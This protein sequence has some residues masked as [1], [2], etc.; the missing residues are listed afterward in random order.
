MNSKK[1]SSNSW[2]ARF[3]LVPST[4]LKVAFLVSI[5]L[6]VYGT[7][8]GSNE[9]VIQIFRD[10]Q[11]ERLAVSLHHGNEIVFGL[12]VGLLT[13]VF[14]WFLLVWLPE[15]KRREIIRTN[16]RRKYHDFKHATMQTLVHAAGQSVDLETIDSLCEHY[17]KFREFFDANDKSL[18]YAAMNGI[19]DESK[20]Y[21]DDILVEYQ[22][23][24]DEFNFA[25]NNIL[26]QDEEVHSFLRRILE[27]VYRLRNYN[28]DRYNLEKLVGQYLFEIFAR[29]SLIDGQRETDYVEDMID[30]I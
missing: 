12:S 23:L 24:A 30:R 16:L 8:S 17:E 6:A 3:F 25:S 27:I 2:R 4:R 28:S 14:V 21:L 20:P 15:Q 10:T 13:G 9:P 22:I 18:W 5:V 29:W 11:V 7:I 26:I 19:A 1:R